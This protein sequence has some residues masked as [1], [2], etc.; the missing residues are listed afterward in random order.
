MVVILFNTPWMV[1]PSFKMPAMLT[2]RDVRQSGDFDDR[3]Q[4]LAA[5]SACFL[6]AIHA[7]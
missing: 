1:V 4:P 7:V 5:A 6:F 3:H 2:C